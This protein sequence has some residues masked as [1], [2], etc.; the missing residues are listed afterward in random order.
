MNRNFFLDFDGTLIDPRDRLYKLF[1]E[2]VP[3]ASFSFEDYWKI[4]NSRVIQSDLLTKWFQYG[5]D[6]IAK[7]KTCWMNKVEERARLDLDRPFEGVSRILGEL[8]NKHGLFLVT[9]RQ[10]PEFVA[11]QLEKF[12][13]SKFFKRILVTEQRSSKAELIR[14][15][16]TFSGD[17]V[18][19]GDTGED[20]QTAHE[21]NLI[22]VAVGSGFLSKEILQSYKP[23]F[24]LNSISELHE[25]GL[26]QS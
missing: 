19:V 5:A 25:T 2:L 12:G 3:E 15:L 11:W 9:A 8:S 7:F 13:W 1:M 6:D 24:L 22:S 18:L 14:S 20:V 4:K 16:Q 23:N 17:D 26:V 10:K 21:L